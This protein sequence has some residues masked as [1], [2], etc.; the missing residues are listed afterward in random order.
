MSAVFSP[1]SIYSLY[2]DGKQEVVSPSR[3]VPFI[4]SPTRSIQPF[5]TTPTSGN[6][7]VSNTA[8][9]AP[10]LSPSSL[11]LVPTLTSP[12]ATS[13]N[14]ATTPSASNAT[15]GGPFFLQLMP[16]VP[17][18]IP[19]PVGSEQSQILFPALSPRSTSLSCIAKAA[20]EEA[21]SE[22]V[23]QAVVVPSSPSKPVAAPQQKVAK[24][25]PPPLSVGNRCLDDV[26]EKAN[27]QV[28]LRLSAAKL[29]KF[30]KYTVELTLKRSLR[31]S[32][33]IA[34]AIIFTAI[35]NAKCCRDGSDVAV[36]CPR[37]GC[38]RVVNVSATAQWPIYN[39]ATDEETYT[40]TVQSKCSSSRD[41]LKSLLVLRIDSLPPILGEIVSDPFVLLAR[42]KGKGKRELAAERA[43]ALGETPKKRKKLSA[44]DQEATQ[45]LRD[46]QNSPTRL[47]PQPAVFVLQSMPNLTP[48]NFPL[49]SPTNTTTTVTPNR[50][51]RN[52]SLSPTTL[53]EALVASSQ[54]EDDDEEEE[55]VNATEDT[56]SRVASNA[57]NPSSPPTTTAASP[58]T[59]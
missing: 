48:A 21:E 37:C 16:N 15:N 8:G 32:A 2:S 47:A 13:A 53:L 18:R 59:A 38:Q 34:E 4:P 57:S 35:L 44:D 39:E 19:S 46:M 49:L 55:E 3:L 36:T 5:V 54:E 51:E 17:F 1:T 56:N 6:I 20:T 42:D 24:K 9:G 14:S 29:C 52:L 7:N 58:V 27:P 10:I 30:R 12:N 31:L 11:L 40:C 45:A 22:K 23:E 26:S 43:L 33:D 28:R 25:R 41:H 50:N